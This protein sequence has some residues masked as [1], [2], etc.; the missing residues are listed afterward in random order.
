M[1]IMVSLSALRPSQYRKYVKGW[2]KGRYA[3]LFAKAAG[4]DAYRIYLPL[5]NEVE[6]SVPAPQEI[7]R[8]ISELGW[9]VEDY[10]AG[11]AVD[12]SGKRR[13]RIGRLLTKHPHL[14]KLFNEDKTRAAYRGKFIICISRHPYDIAGAST[15]RGWTSCMNLV[16][17]ENRHFIAREVAI[18]SLIA[19]LIEEHDTNIKRPTARTMIKPFYKDD[20]KELLHPLLIADPAV[21]GT[22]VKGFVRTVQRWLDKN[23]NHKRTEGVY[24]IHEDSYEDGYNTHL[25]TNDDPDHLRFKYDLRKDPNNYLTSIVSEDE[26]RLAFRS[27]P[28]LMQ[29][30]D[31][32][33]LSD[34][35]KGAAA[36]PN[37]AFQIMLDHPDRIFDGR[38]ATR[39][40]FHDDNIRRAEIRYLIQHNP[41]FFRVAEDRLKFRDDE[42][43]DIL[44]FNGEVIGPQIPESR[45]NGEILRGL[46]KYLN[47]DKLAA[48]T[49]HIPRSLIPADPLE[50]VRAYPRMVLFFK[51]PYL[52][53]VKAAL[54]GVVKDDWKAIIYTMRT[55][56]LTRPIADYMISWLMTHQQPSD[57]IRFCYDRLMTEGASKSPVV[58]D[59]VLI[60][61]CLA[62]GEKEGFDLDKRFRICHMLNHL[63]AEKRIERYKTGLY[64]NVLNAAF[65]DKMVNITAEECSVVI[66]QDEGVDFFRASLNVLWELATK[67]P[68]A[69][70]TGI[71]Y[72]VD[73]PHTD[74]ILELPMCNIANP[75][76][77]RSIAA[78]PEYNEFGLYCMR[79]LLGASKLFGDTVTGYYVRSNP[80]YQKLYAEMRPD[81]PNYMKE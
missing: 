47:N 46:L 81:L 71:D 41:G 59:P 56:L 21:Y 15:D 35:R 38:D 52:E 69:F 61:R 44:V 20:D 76:L 50:R 53:L 55:E 22:N 72:T 24:R 65:E 17:G 14:L 54:D 34:W 49:K 39:S 60:E 68:K 6:V 80:E 2:D 13:M 58:D 27:Y 75:S 67:A 40:L 78:N 63:P 3:A 79:R 31:R 66:H 28:Q 57:V 48:M 70:C 64:F 4:K 77:W 19:Y 51:E 25:K 30:V 62:F 12:K 7:A 45:W 74:T 16:D 33:L 9:A 32:M 8:T 11:I 23:I 26:R 36:D 42:L 37:T 18:G 43:V 29:L 5:D 1:K 73:H 10:R